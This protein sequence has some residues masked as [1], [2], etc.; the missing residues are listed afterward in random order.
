MTIWTLIATG[1]FA[2]AGVLNMYAGYLYMKLN[3]QGIIFSNKR[4]SWKLLKA[5]L[6]KSNDAAIKQAI[7][8]CFNVYKLYLLSFYAAMVLI[9]IALLL[10]G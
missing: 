7:T 8:K 1:S 9:I 6:I 4:V 10:P 5:N 2:L 3:R